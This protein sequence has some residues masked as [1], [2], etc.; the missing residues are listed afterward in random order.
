MYEPF[1][2]LLPS[3]PNCNLY[4]LLRKVELR[5][6]NPTLTLALHMH[7]TFLTFKR[8]ASIVN[9]LMKLYAQAMRLSVVNCQSAGF[10]I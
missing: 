10:E 9:T 3:Y 5:I 8:Y 6:F 1:K 2:L 7:I 4:N